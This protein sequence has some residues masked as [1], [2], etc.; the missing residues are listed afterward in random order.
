MYASNAAA[1]RYYTQATTRTRNG[2]GVGQTIESAIT[3]EDILRLAEQ[4]A[5]KAVQA[6]ELMA[7]YIG[8]GL[9]NLVTGLAPDAI[10]IIGEVTR[11]W[12]R[13]G[14]IIA[15]V[16]KERCFTHAAPVIHA[17][18]PASQPRLRGTIAL[19]LQEHFGAPVVA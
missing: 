8:I 13:V 7:S 16:I 4:D 3:I 1:V 18:D 10:V 15:K 17:T 19:V 14:P 12:Q 9:A 6:L 11:A 5:P 2:K